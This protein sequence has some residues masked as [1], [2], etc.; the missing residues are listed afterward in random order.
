MIDVVFLLIIFFLVSS[1][2]ARQESR[3]PLELPVAERSDELTITENR[4]T[5]NVLDPDTLQVA[6]IL[7]DQ[8]R[9]RKMLLEHR[10]EHGKD[11]PVRIR[12]NQDVPYRVIEPILRAAA[13]A[14]LWNASF[15]VHQETQ[16]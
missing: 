11:A 10:N 12:S 14:G 1:H 8:S 6:G 4:L 16:R 13:N 9:L 3:I 7:V 5:V 2:L 15:A